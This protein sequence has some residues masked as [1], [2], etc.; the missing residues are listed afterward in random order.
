MSLPIV[1]REVARAEFEDAAA[2]YESRVANLGADFIAEIQRVLDTIADHPNRF[3]V[4]FGDVREVLVRRFP[5]C[6]YY[7]VKL[8]R[9]VIIAVFHTS[10]DRTEWQ[11]RA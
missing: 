11:S 5:Y 8:D 7:R 1:F 2:W 3:P 10:R 6:V 9:L 4:V